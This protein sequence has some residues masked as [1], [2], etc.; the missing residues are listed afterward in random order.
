MTWHGFE[1]NERHKAKNDISAIELL[2]NY[3][4]QFWQKCQYWTEIIQNNGYVFN[5]ELVEILVQSSDMKENFQ[6]RGSIYPYQRRLQ[7]AVTCT[8]MIGSSLPFCLS[9][10][11]Q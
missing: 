5:G 6:A 9:A 4:E 8:G 2:A 10:L 11:P 7:E 3:C 1:I